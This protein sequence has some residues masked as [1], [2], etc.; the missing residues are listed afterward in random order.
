MNWRLIC[1]IASSAGVLVC[2]DLADRQRLMPN[3]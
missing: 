3:W 2:R 1:L